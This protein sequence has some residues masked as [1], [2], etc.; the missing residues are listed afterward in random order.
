M[1][2][3]VGP[4]AAAVTG[5][6]L[7]SVSAC[8]SPLEVRG[9][10]ERIAIGRVYEQD[11]A[12]DTVRRYSFVTDATGEYAV[13]LQAR[14]GSVQL[15]VVDSLTNQ[16]VASGFASLASGSLEQNASHWFQSSGQTVFLLRVNA[17]PPGTA[18][19]FRFLVYPVDPAPEQRPAAFVLGD[20][21]SGEELA[22]AADIDRFV[23]PGQAGQ[24][25]VAV[26]EALGPVGSG[27]LLLAMTEPSDIFGAT[28]APAGLAAS[29][30]TG[31]IRLPVSGDY[32][33]EVLSLFGNVPG[34]RGPYR[35]WTYVIDRA[36]E[37]IPAGAPIGSAVSGEAIDRAGDVD[38]FVLQAQA[39]DEFNI[40]LQAAHH[41]RLEVA[42]GSG[43]LIAATSAPMLDTSLF[44]WATGRFQVPQS[45]V[46]TVRV[47]GQFSQA[48]ADTG[49]YRFFIYPVDRRPERVTATI[50]EGDT[51]AGEAID[52][53]GDVDE[54]TFS[55]TAGVEF[56]VLFQALSG[57]PVTV[58]RL[59]AV[60]DTGGVLAAV[61]SLGSD[62]SLFQRVTGRFRTTGSGTHRLRVTGAGHTGVGPYRLSLYR[63]DRTPEVLPDTLAFGDSIS[64]EAIDVP[65][66]VDEYRVVVP[67]ASG[68]N[69]VVQVGDLVPGGGIVAVLF[70]SATGVPSAGAQVLIPGTSMSGTTELDAGV[71][72]LR[73]EG[74][75][76]EDHALP[77]RLWAYRF[78]FGAEQVADTIAIGDTVSG[79]AIDPVGDVDNLVLFGEQ[80]QHINLALQG[81][82]D[83]A[84]GGL[85]AFIE[86]ALPL[87]V[88]NSA[89][90]AGPMGASRSNR[91]DLPAT[92][93]YRIR[94][95]SSGSPLPGLGDRGPYRL[96]VT[97]LGVSP[98][99]AGAALA[100]GDS[101]ANESLDF[102]GDWDEYVV[103][104]TP[105]QRLA[106]VGRNVTATGYPELAVFDPATHDTL[107]WFPM[108]GF[109]RTTPRF[110]M[111]TGG[112]VG[113]VVYERRGG[114]FGN[115]FVSCYDPTCD[116]VYT[117]V[118]GYRLTVFAVNPAPE[119]VP[120]SFAL[121]DTVR[122]EDVT[123]VTDV[124]EFLGTGVP[125]DTMSVWARLLLDPV[126]ARGLIS[127]DIVDPT[128]GFVL[129]GGFGLISAHPTG[130]FGSPGAFAV[131]AS[132]AYLIRIY[133]GGTFGDEL[134]VAPY[135]FYAKRGP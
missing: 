120:A 14:Q 1:R 89:T 46:T 40:F 42:S 72:V 77:Y 28:T 125:G 35:F 55:G 13:L 131:P 116:G 54:F 114:L 108:Q 12:G 102:A 99:L 30:T 81:L 34:Y 105:G 18:A 61:S 19:R 32:E 64:G 106:V 56:N 97:L 115:G 3:R 91:I 39:G 85:S 82:A 132:G 24:D 36:P 80:G 53:P 103:T 75:R 37:R 66:D 4:V 110:T 88:V 60:D 48:V 123:P 21:V 86:G 113:V 49:T 135:E 128:T 78:R 15:S 2:R 47:D 17:W 71:Y 93:Q 87:S 127:V 23:A 84:T 133:S 20:T 50:G 104:A 57:S 134:G 27:T 33:F 22:T 119:H 9:E 118:G 101:V 41:F 90:S 69:L 98:E 100:L 6:A 95:G 70:D 16:E 112:R 59:E 96:S 94:V 11:V 38:E 29:Q 124:D 26:A 5:V 65:G 25:V 7:L 58:L 10:G 51:V 109:D 79:E 129:R 31:R 111:P 92:G 74:A 73:V 68:F 67:T 62:T 107:G 126:P 44:R 76:A 45:G 121:G 83:S 117:A 43:A 130:G 122:G 8:E 52:I 63:V